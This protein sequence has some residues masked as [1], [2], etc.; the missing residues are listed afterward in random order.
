MNVLILAGH[1]KRNMIERMVSH[2]STEIQPTILTPPPGIRALRKAIAKF[3]PDLIFT[4]VPTYGLHAYLKLR[5]PFIIHLRGDWW[6]EWASASRSWSLAKKVV[7]QRYWYENTWAFRSSKQIIPICRW[8]EKIVHEHVNKE[9]TVIHQGIESSDWQPLEGLNLE[10]PA[11]AIIQDHTIHPKVKGLVDFSSVA[12]KCQQVQFYISEGHRWSN[13][14]YLDE[15][16]R[17]F[18][19]MRNVHFVSG[20]DNM[21]A[22]RKLLTACDCYLL[23]SGLDC[24]PTT[25]LEASLLRKPVIAS[26]VGGVPEL[27]REGVTGWTVKD[28]DEWLQ[29][30]SLVASDPKYARHMGERGREY[31]QANFDWSV[32]APKYERE[33]LA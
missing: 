16:K 18:H 9:T 19:D 29:W 23:A 5:K 8:L 27:V 30:I 11:F 32:I 1:E 13:V 24:C 15:V 28:D 2:F 22:V 3:R 4:D 26:R 14:D 7:L 25:V 10:H 33:F 17:A 20:I 12:S 6:S 21:E 31:V